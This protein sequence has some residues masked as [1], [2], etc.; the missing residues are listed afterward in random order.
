VK[1]DFSNADDY[2]ALVI[3]NDSLADVDQ[4]RYRLVRLDSPFEGRD[5]KHGSIVIAV[6]RA[7]Q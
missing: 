5:D 3:E 2:D 7:R 1:K 4:S 6:K